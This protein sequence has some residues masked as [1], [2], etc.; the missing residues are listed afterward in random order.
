MIT[1]NQLVEAIRQVAATEPDF[2]YDGDGN[3]SCNYAPN[4]SNR[5]GCIV[6]E[7]L[8]L[9]GVPRERLRALDLIGHETAIGWGCP[10]VAREL[11]DLVEPAALDSDWVQCVQVEQDKGSAWADA[12]LTA[13]Q[14]C[15][16]GL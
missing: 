13:D 7:A 8:H 4:A 3:D 10:Q 9:L 15:R 6:G 2:I 12:V 5:C 14:Q 11:G 16:E 1:L